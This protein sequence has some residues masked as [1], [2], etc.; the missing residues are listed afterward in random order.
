MGTPYQPA[1]TKN[2]NK[3]QIFPPPK[4]VLIKE[5]GHFTTCGIELLL[6]HNLKIGMNFSLSKLKALPYIFL[7]CKRYDLETAI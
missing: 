3:N 1:Q 4:L 5:N 2:Q 7:I 6:L